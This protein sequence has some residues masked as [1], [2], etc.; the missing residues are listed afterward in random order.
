MDGSKNVNMIEL[1]ESGGGAQVR[2]ELGANI[3]L[4]SLRNQ[5]VPKSLCSNPRWSKSQLLCNNNKHLSCLYTNATSLNNKFEELIVE[6][7]SVNA[8]IVFVC[9]TW[10]TE[11]SV[12]NIPGYSLFRKDRIGVGEEAFVFILITV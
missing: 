5:K 3:L 11:T 10:W 8:Q 6:I 2:N 7:N 12:T 1:R 4:G 9:E